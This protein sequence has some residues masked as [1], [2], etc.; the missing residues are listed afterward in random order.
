MPSKRKYDEKNPSVTFRMSKEEK[1]ELEK[2]SKLLNMSTSEII[3]EF[4]FNQKEGAIKLF[5]NGIKHGRQLEREQNRIFYFCSIC[6]KKIFIEPNTHEHHA[7][8]QYMLM[9]GWGHR[10]CH[11]KNRQMNNK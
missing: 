4:F 7:M 2:M 8:I 5:N 9:Y 1:I 11:N 10:E 6:N 3:H